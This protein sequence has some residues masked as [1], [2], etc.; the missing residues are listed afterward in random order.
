V[1]TCNQL[2]A[3]TI[4]Q[5]LKRSSSIGALDAS[6]PTEGGLGTL[7]VALEIAVSAARPLLIA[8]RSGVDASTPLPIGSGSGWG[9]LGRVAPIP[10]ALHSRRGEMSSAGNRSWL[11]DVQNRL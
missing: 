2:M 6:A 11:R 5:L 3:E 4:D 8:V 9:Q 10:T 1:V 7:L